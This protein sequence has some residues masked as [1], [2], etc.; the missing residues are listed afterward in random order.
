MTRPVLYP[1][2]EI[3]DPVGMALARSLQGLC[4]SRGARVLVPLIQAGLQLDP[5]LGA[6]LESLCQKAGSTLF[7][8]IFDFRESGRG[9]M[10]I[11][12]MGLW[13]FPCAGGENLQFFLLSVAL[14][15]QFHFYN[16]ESLS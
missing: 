1:F 7:D 3:K 16:H 6:G 2:Q 11:I 4:T 14:Y 5:K 9:G 15:I 12:E 10:M 8:W 13:F